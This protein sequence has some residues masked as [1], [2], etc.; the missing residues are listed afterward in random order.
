MR[1]L[2]PLALL[3][4]VSCNQADVPSGNGSQDVA[5]WIDP[6]TGCVYLVYGRGMGQSRVGSLSVRF[7]ADGVADCPD[8]PTRSSREDSELSGSP[9]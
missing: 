4:L 2:L 3:A 7:R 1:A 9:R 5:R 8:A 6:E